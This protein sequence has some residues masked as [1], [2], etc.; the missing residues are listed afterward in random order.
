VETAEAAV[1]ARLAAAAQTL[2][3]ATP[4][5]EALQLVADIRECAAALREVLA[6]KGA[7]R[8]QEKL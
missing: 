8:R 4:R 7:L 1:A 6:C 2:G 3:A 5:L